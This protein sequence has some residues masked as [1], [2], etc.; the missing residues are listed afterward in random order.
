MLLRLNCVCCKAICFNEQWQLHR[1]LG[2][3]KQKQP[4][5]QRPPPPMDAYQLNVDKLT[6]SCFP[7]LTVKFAVGHCIAALYVLVL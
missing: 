2:K 7:S 3:Q 1:Q 5:I 6:H 4:S